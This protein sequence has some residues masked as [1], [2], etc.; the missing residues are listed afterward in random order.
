MSRYRTIKPEFWASEQIVLLSMQ[1]R[2][3]FIGMWN[4]ADDNG[5]LP[6][7]FINIKAKIFPIDNCSLA[8]IKNWINELIQQKLIKEYQIDDKS[9]WM[10][11][12][13]KIHQKIDKPSYKYPE[14]LQ[15]DNNSANKNESSVEIKEHSA[16][17]TYPSDKI[18]DASETFAEGSPLE[19]SREEKRGKEKNGEEG[20]VRGGVPAAPVAQARR[21]EQLSDPP[22]KSK[23]EN[24]T[25]EIAE[26]F[27]H[28]QAVTGYPRAKLD[29]KRKRLIRD[30]LKLGYTV[31]DLKNAISGCAKTPH[32][33]G[34]NERGQAYMGLHVILRNADQIDRFIKN[35]HSPP[36]LQNKAALRTKSNLS[37]VEQFV[38]EESD[39]DAD[40]S[41]FEEGEIYENSG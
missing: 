30:A 14:P 6:A 33:Q 11:T 21:R 26:A 13:F 12:G 23:R 37:A 32:N 40:S 38:M 8:D 24:F 27:E 1:A 15:N 39:P 22:E 2:L 41:K 36:R 3:M 20:S 7:S 18:A 4:F 19:R 10:I 5:V 16:K 28:W 25:E 17:N 9:Y 31:G 35:F 29:D 34:H